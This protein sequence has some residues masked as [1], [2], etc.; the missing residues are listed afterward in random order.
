M[1]RR[2]IF[3]WR[4][5]KTTYPAEDLESLAHRAPRPIDLLFV[6]PVLTYERQVTHRKPAIEE[7]CYWLQID[8]I[9][10]ASRPPGVVAHVL[11]RMVR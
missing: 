4:G 9:P 2:H 6:F 10:C 1:L 5:C 8:Y 11:L 3:D 7:A